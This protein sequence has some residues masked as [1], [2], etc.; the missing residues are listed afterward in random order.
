MIEK[1][2]DVV[3]SKTQ[4]MKKV[5]GSLLGSNEHIDMYEEIRKNAGLNQAILKS[6]TD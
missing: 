6:I 4:Q 5:I 3:E 1:N 2:V